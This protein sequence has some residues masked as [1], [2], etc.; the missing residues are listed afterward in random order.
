[1]TRIDNSTG[2]DDPQP[3]GQH[4]NNQDPPPTIPNDFQQIDSDSEDY[5]N[6]NDDNN[7]GETSPYFGLAL[8]AN[9]LPNEDE[10]EDNIRLQQSPPTTASNNDEQTSGT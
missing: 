3:H 7:A 10:N 6:G 4:I 9:N 8:P 2:M 1:M 5:G